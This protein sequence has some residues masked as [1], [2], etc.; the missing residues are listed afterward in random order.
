MNWLKVWQQTVSQLKT[1]G[2]TGDEKSLDAVSAYVEKNID[3]LED[4]EGKPI[5]LKELYAKA[6][7]SKPNLRLTT[8]AKDVEIET[9]REQLATK[10]LEDELTGKNKSRNRQREDNRAL[11]ITVG[12][13]RLIDDPKGGFKSFGHF[14]QSVIK[15]PG[16][17]NDR[18]GIF[19]P[20]DNTPLQ[21]WSKAYGEKVMDEA[22]EAFAAGLINKATLSTYSSEG[23]GADGGFAVPP[24]FMA[25]VMN[26]VEAPESIAAKCDRATLSGNTITATIDQTTPWQTSGGILTYWIGEATAI[27]QS[28]LSLQQRTFTLRKLAALVP[29]T[30]ELEQDASFLGT[31]V[32]GK[33]GDKLGFALDKSILFGDGVT[34][35]TGVVGHAGT[36]SV[37]KETNQTAATIKATNI[38]KM[39][40]SM[41][42]AL[43]RE[44][45]WLANEDVFPSLA[46]MFIQGTRDSNTSIAAGSVVWL[47]ANGLA[48]QPNE[49][50]MGRPIVYHQAAQTL[51]T[52]GDLI[53]FHPKSYLVCT[54]ASGI[55][56]VGSIHLWFDQAVNALRFLY[57]V[58]GQPWWPTTIAAL[59]GTQTYGA[60]VTLATRA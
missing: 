3:V 55:Q 42:A 39:W 6:F 47:P 1:H 5:D 43:R 24:E 33:A 45:I 38:L 9:L 29:L 50:L 28:K 13:D 37:A 51:G 2:Y 14:I 25:G 52:V 4:S 41:P 46:R 20:R 49:T 7:P 18:G 36:V 12:K 31:Y 32:T 23:T 16:S 35:P 17:G 21:R 19:T 10:E 15:C 54:K 58:E 11:D 48:G 60:F 40:T 26:R 8:S 59:N 27:T 44:A 57:R 53:L 30:E 22:N 56:A 34:Q